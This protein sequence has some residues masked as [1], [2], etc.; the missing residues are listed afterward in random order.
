[1]THAEDRVRILEEAHEWLGTPF[2]HMGRVKGAGV[3]CG[4][5]PA[6]V[7]EAAGLI[8]HYE[9]EYYPPDFHVHQNTEV[10]LSH[11]EKFT[12]RVQCPLPGDLALFRFGRVISHGAIIVA[13]PLI[14]HAYIT[15]GC[16]VLD[17]AEV[18]P[19]LSKRLVGFW[20]LWGGE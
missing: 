1:M 11:C 4:Q 8:P 10:W 15:A 5:F 6:A 7:Y 18:N 12:K 3:D 20:S 19:D 2:L 17:D 16:V 14:I 9:T 13:W